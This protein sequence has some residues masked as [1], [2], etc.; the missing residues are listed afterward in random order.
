MATGSGW[1]THSNKTQP[2][3]IQLQGQMRRGGDVAEH[4]ARL[5]RRSWQVFS[6]P[7]MRQPLCHR[8][9]N[10]AYSAERVAHPLTPIR[11]L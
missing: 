9:A 3:A 11:V 8:L 4:S 1:A 2:S 7:Q 6:S 5:L 10:H